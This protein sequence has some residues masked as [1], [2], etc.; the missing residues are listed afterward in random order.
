MKL[1]ACIHLH[2]IFPSYLVRS[3]YII[4]QVLQV[5]R[6]MSSNLPIHVF[7]R[8]Y[9]NTPPMLNKPS[10][11]ETQNR[12]YPIK[13]GRNFNDE[14]HHSQNE[15]HQCYMHAHTAKTGLDEEGVSASCHACHVSSCDSFCT[16][17]PSGP[18]CISSS[19][20]TRR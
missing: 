20:R 8:I 19:S 1:P 12:R 18:F 2:I 11:L 10:P 7:I 4:G 6:I 16:F 9:K 13:I 15:G 3:L 14:A 17:V 5:Q